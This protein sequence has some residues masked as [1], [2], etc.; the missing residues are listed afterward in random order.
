MATA[1]TATSTRTTTRV[2]ITH[3]CGHKRRVTLHS[4]GAARKSAEL[5][6]LA[7]HDCPACI[8]ELAPRR[9]A[10]IEQPAEQPTPVTPVARQLTWLKREA[11]DVE[12][13]LA[14]LTHTAVQI[15]EASGWRDARLPQIDETIHYWKGR[16]LALTRQISALSLQNLQVATQVA[17]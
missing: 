8:D 10:Q 17:H 7:A 1:T 16:Y 13:N 4:V 2:T 9:A 3:A 6:D 12:E 15:G 11:S 5:F 14:S